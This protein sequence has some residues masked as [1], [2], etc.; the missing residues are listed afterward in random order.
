MN[1][2]PL[3]PPALERRTHPPHG[4]VQAVLKLLNRAHLVLRCQ[5]LPQRLYRIDPV[6]RLLCRFLGRDVLK[7]WVS[8]DMWVGALPCPLSVISPQ[9]FINAFIDGVRLLPGDLS[10][11]NGLSLHLLERNDGHHALWADSELFGEM[12]D[13]EL[14]RVVGVEVVHIPFGPIAQQRVDFVVW[15]STAGEVT[16]PHVKALLTLLPI[17]LALPDKVPGRLS[18]CTLWIVIFGGFL[19]KLGAVIVPAPAISRAIATSRV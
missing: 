4:K 5:F 11:L 16:L 10:L 14:F 1:F 17:H 9:F 6:V 12:L 8:R 18:G 2:P 3:S 19:K 13:A 15:D 7:L